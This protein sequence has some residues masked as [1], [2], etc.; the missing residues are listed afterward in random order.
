MSLRSRL[1]P[2]FSRYLNTPIS[3]QKS[4]LCDF[5]RIK[6]EIRLCDVLLVEGRSR[7]SRVIRSVSNSAWTH[8]ALYIGRLSDIE[9]PLLRERVQ[10]SYQGSPHDRLVIESIVGKGTAVTP[11]SFYEKEHLRICRPSGLHHADAQKIITYTIGHIGHPY[12]MRQIFDLWRYYLGWFFI[13]KKWL[14]SL[15]E[16]K[17]TPSKEDVCSVLIASAFKTI[18]FPIRPLIRQDNNS[19]LEMIHRNPWLTTPA[20]FD[21]S[22]YF[23]IIKYPILPTNKHSAYRNLPWNEE[24]LS[25]DD[26]GVSEIATNATNNEENAKK[27]V[28]QTEE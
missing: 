27:S 28:P 12:N 11:L 10:Q 16:Y 14:S 15:F 2:R 8:A 26:E 20:D 23:D 3:P 18:K 13:P 7:V 1:L 25:H 24:L 17:P 21:F 19:D 9:D 6:H 5:E 22:P 4:Y